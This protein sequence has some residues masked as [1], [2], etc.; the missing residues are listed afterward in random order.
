MRLFISLLRTLERN[1]P[2]YGRFSALFL[3]SPEMAKSW[4]H[5]GSKSGNNS[6]GE[7]A[8]ESLFSK[9]VRK[10]HVPADEKLN[11]ARSHC[12]DSDPFALLIT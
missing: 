6:I 4:S 12:Q 7:K 9:A 1:I 8:G 3:E 11:P 10:S 2:G 5:N